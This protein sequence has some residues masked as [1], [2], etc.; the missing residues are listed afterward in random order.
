MAKNSESSK[1]YKYVSKNEVFDTL[2][3]ILQ[4]AAPRMQVKF[5][6]GCNYHDHMNLEKVILISKIQGHKNSSRGMVGLPY[7]KN[8]FF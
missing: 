5:D 3:K 6:F 8:V 2:L 1:N 7:V 4:W